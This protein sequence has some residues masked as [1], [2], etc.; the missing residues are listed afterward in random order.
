[1]RNSQKHRQEKSREGT[2]HVPSTTKQR[3]ALRFISNLRQ[4]QFKQSKTMACK[5]WGGIY[6]HQQS[7]LCPARGKICTVSKNPNH[8][9]RVC[10]SKL[11]TESVRQIEDNRHNESSSEDIFSV[12]SNKRV[13]TATIRLNNQTVTCV[14]DT[15][16]SVNI[17][18]KQTFDRFRK[19]P[20]LSPS[21]TAILTT[22]Q[23]RNFLSWVALQQIPPTKRIK[24]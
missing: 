12:K 13:P 20:V 23:N 8:F 7:K 22:I 4:Q 10:R 19:K 21:S 18:T 17:I 9:A 14:V 24:F 15:G 1:M 3:G 5:N 6:P 2:K 11:K 16:A